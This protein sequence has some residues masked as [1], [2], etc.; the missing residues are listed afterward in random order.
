MVVVD[1]ESVVGDEV[2]VEPELPVVPVVDGL[3]GPVEAVVDVDSWKMNSLERNE[4]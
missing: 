1:V 3:V 4:K 2:S